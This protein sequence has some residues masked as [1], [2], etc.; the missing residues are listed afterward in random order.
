LWGGTA[1]SIIEPLNPLLDEDS[2]VNLLDI[3]EAEILFALGPQ[4]QLGIWEK[5]LTVATKSKK[6]KK[7]YSVLTADPASD[8][9]HYDTEVAKES[10]AALPQEWL[11]A[12]DDIAS[13]FH[14]GGTTGTPKLAMHS[15]RNH[16]VAARTL[17]K[18]SGLKA[19]EVA[20]NGLPLFHLG[21]T[22]MNALSVLIGGMSVILPTIAGYRNSAV[23]ENFWQLVEHYRIACNLC[24]ATSMSAFLQI[25][26]G[27]ADISSLH[28]SACGGAAVPDSVSDA[29]LRETG[30]PLYQAYGSTETT[31]LCAIPAAHVETIKGCAGWVPPEVE[32]R[33]GDG[34][35]ASCEAGEIFVRGEAVFKGYVQQSENHI[36]ADGW[37]ATGDLGYLNEDGRLFLSGRCKDLII[38]GGHNI[39]PTA[40]EAC[41][42]KHPAINLADAV[43]KPDSYAGEL[44]IAYVQL[45][46]GQTVTAEELQVFAAEHIH[47]RPACPKQIIILD[48]LP[49]TAMGK[50]HKPTL[51]EAAVKLMVQE[52]L[53]ESFP[54]FQSDIT[55]SVAKNGLTQVNV[56]ADTHS[57]EVAALLD[58]LQAELK[59]IINL[60]TV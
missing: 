31:S 55:I 17:N 22:T 45:N 19:G 28:L 49:L 43:A 40:I 44:P 18:Y 7:V 30:H 54:A 58:K 6:L 20:I 11:P 12:A 32:I 26:V 1:V 5:A 21:G 23:V 3:A 10:V 16:I 56:V 25:P 2:L 52:S 42:E 24:V 50:I 15:H 57:D 51:R 60:E 59:L 14:T 13:Y 29:V 53:A 34:N 27:N 39:D 47:E 8:H 41:L 48:A 33:I 9:P 37:F 35:C 4:P 38:R 46:P 36:D